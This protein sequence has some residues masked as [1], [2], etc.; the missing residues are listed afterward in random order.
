MKQPFPF[1]VV[2]MD[3]SPSYFG[4]ETPHPSEA[5]FKSLSSRKPFPVPR[6]LAD[7]TCPKSLLSNSFPSISYFFLP[8]ILTP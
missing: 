8:K 1:S 3:L 6:V 7:L 5:R 4:G 2:Q